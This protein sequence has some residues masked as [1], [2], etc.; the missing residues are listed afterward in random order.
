VKLTD[1]GLARAA[2]DV[3]LTSTGFVSGTPLYMAPE[4]ALGGEADPRSDL[5]SLGAILYEMSTGQPPFTGNSALAILK[6]ITETRHRPL[7][8]LNPAIPE[9]MAETIDRLLA[10]KPADRIQSA[11]HLA[12]LFEF[13]WALLKTTS[14]D[15]P[16]VCQIEER[17]QTIRNR[18]M[19]VVIGAAF[20]AIGLAGGQYWGRQGAPI[21]GQAGELKSSAEPIAVLSANAGAV[22]SVSFDK[23]SETV[24]M[25]VEDGSVRLWNLPT[26]SVESTFNAHRGNIWAARFSQSCEVLATAGDDG[27][28]KLWR[29]GQPE[30]IR[31]Y[32]H[33]S[34]VRGMIFSHDDHKIYSSDREGGLRVWSIDSDEPIEEAKEAGTAYALA[35]S[36]NDEVLASAGSDKVVRLW[37]AKTLAPKLVLEGHAG[38]VYGLSFHPEGRRLASSGWD[39]TVRIW[40]VGSGLLIKSWEGHAGDIWGIAYSADG[41]RRRRESVE[42]RNRPT[43]GH[44][45]RPQN[46]DPHDLVQPN[47]NII[48]LR[49]KRRCGAD[50]ENRVERALRRVTLRRSGPVGRP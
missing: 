10:K 22:W 4:Q 14:E 34:A 44:L 5:F 35:L 17:K 2:E 33:N 50:L 41:K 7:R 12:E 32:H 29:P 1:F 27:L 43:T 16:T 11:A 45:S 31:I 18:I 15:V 13:Q 47:R 38:P 48:G 20:L 19:A 39:K 30:P 28:V 3:R 36:P 9:W 42:R 40:D 24:A 37:N 23:K 21:I 26:K 25:G 49:R 8:E 6:Q 46:R